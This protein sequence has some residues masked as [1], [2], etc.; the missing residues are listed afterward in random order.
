MLFLDAQ[1]NPSV[2]TVSHNDICVISCGGDAEFD[3]QVNYRSVD[4]KS[5][6]AH[7]TYMRGAVVLTHDR[8][9]IFAL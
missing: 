8:V 7:I 1:D 3:L 9:C 5:A 4:R 6:N 2:N